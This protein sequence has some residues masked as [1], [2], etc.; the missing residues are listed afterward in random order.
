VVA[1]LRR[2]AFWVAVSLPALYPLALLHAAGTLPERLAV[3]AVPPGG[4]LTA[5]LVAHAAV[6]ALGHDHR[7]D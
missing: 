3:G 6:V 5:L 2:V 4:V 7:P 1:G